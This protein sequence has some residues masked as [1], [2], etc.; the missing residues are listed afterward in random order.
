MPAE[1]SAIQ[2]MALPE[3]WPPVS[4]EPVT[5][6]SLPD[7]GHPKPS[8]LEHEPTLTMEQGPALPRQIAVLLVEVLA[9]VRQERQVTQWLSKRGRLHLHRLMPLFNTGHQP[10]VL[11]V[12][13]TRPA[14]DVV[15]M[16]IIAAIGH[17]PRALAIRLEYS[18][19]PGRWL[20]TDIESG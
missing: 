5:N 17:R 6:A 8:P 20:C 19:Q 9:G 11:R 18:A 15:E 7:A 1:E 3:L 10:R 2:L 12:L 16:T 13:M 4:Q 14:P